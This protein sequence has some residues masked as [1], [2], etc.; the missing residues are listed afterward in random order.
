MRTILWQS[1]E[2]VF[3]GRKGVENFL[4]ASNL[5][6]GE[7][8]DSL[9]PSR[10]PMLGP[11]N[12]II[13]CLKWKKYIILVP[14]GG[15]HTKFQVGFYDEVY[16]TCKMSSAIRKVYDGPFAMRMGPNDCYFFIVGYNE[17]VTLEVAGYTR[18]DIDL[19]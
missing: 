19:Y 3:Y 14:K 2:T 1:W 15:L 17:V 5:V 12:W 7:R 10:S 13:K 16:G 6:K 18:K 11:I 4:Y 8:D 9:R